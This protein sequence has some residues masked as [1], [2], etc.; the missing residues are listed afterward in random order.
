MVDTYVVD[1]DGNPIP[2]T[3]LWVTSLAEEHGRVIKSTIG[4]QQ[5]DKDGYA[6]LGGLAAAK[7]QY[8]ITAVHTKYGKWIKENNRKYRDCKIYRWNT[9]QRM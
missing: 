9:C 6:L 5:T 3:P 4:T 1:E 8:L 7:T 2:D